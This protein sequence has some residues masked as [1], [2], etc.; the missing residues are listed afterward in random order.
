MKVLYRRYVS[1]LLL[2]GL[3][4]LLT[5][6]TATASSARLTDDE[7][8]ATTAKKSTILRGRAS[9]YGREFQGR[10]TSSGERFDRHQYTCAHKT[11]PFGTRLRV[12]NPKT[13]EAVVVRVSDR[14][15]FR[16]QRI[17]DLAEVAARPLGIVTHGAVSVVAEI[18]PDTTPLG[19]T[20]APD[21]LQALAVD[22]AELAALHT[23]IVAGSTEDADVAVTAEPTAS[24]TVQAGTFGDVRNARATIEKIQGLEPGLFVT[25][26]TSA[27]A[28]GKTLNR[29]VVGRFATAAEANAVRLRLARAGVAGLVRQSENL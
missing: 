25:T 6:Q 14:G 21:D 22:P 8:A 12:S 18:V 24:Y 19:P 15:P 17:L 20:N 26:L 2:V 3:T 16:H 11:L 5:L 13:G 4:A 10:R 23:N 27:S 29:V 1:S 7:K 9:W 28:Q